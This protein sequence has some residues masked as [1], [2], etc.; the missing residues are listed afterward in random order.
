MPA[1]VSKAGSK[2][3]LSGQKVDAERNQTGLLC[4]AL[5]TVRQHHFRLN[6]CASIDICYNATSTLLC[7]YKVPRQVRMQFCT[8]TGATVK[9]VSCCACPDHAVQHD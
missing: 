6:V 7:K 1:A 5:G 4:S 2:L 3:V 8:V 9:S